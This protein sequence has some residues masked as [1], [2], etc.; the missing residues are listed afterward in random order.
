MVEQI[1]DTKF[2]KLEDFLKNRRTTLMPSSHRNFKLEKSSKK[3]NLFEID[4]KLNL[5]NF[6]KSQN[7]I[8]EKI[9]LKTH[10]ER[11]HI[12]IENKDTDNKDNKIE[13]KEKIVRKS[14]FLNNEPY[15]EDINP[16]P[17]EEIFKSSC[18]EKKIDPYF[19]ELFQDQ[20]ERL[21]KISPFGKLETWKI[22]KMIGIVNK[23]LFNFS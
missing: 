2:L 10:R 6:N 16:E 12:S 13:E 5:S 3:N 18:S 11:Y 17:M 22:F 19:G 23:I 4:E 7:D 9:V 21:R 8:E 1:D 20:S 15:E 14:N